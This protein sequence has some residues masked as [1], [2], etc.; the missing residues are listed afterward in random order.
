MKKIIFIIYATVISATFLCAL[1]LKEH[2]NIVI[3]SLIPAGVC[4]LQLYFGWLL[5]KGYAYISGGKLR[6]AYFRNFY[7]GDLK[8]TKNER[9][10]GSFEKVG[11]LSGENEYEKRSRMLS[12]Y[13]FLIFA[14][15]AIPFI[16][17][18]TPRTKFG[19][20]GILL[21]SIVL[22]TVINA[23]VDMSAV[24]NERKIQR[25]N[26]EQWAKELEEQKRREEMGK[27][28]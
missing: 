13:V 25:K 16:F 19:S 15:A 24:A 12:G 6:W 1:M 3:D 20:L 21:A 18:F 23:V 22:A 11:R 7:N 28:K 5:V 4:V 14:A 8:F 26:D 27:W 2:L 17:F 10:K 9:G